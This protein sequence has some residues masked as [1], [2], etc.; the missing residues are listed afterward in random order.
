M[1]HL[2]RVWESAVA[3]VSLSSLFPLSLSSSPPS[4]PSVIVMPGVSPSPGVPALVP[5][6]SHSFSDFVMRDSAVSPSGL[7]DWNTDLVKSLRL[8][9]CFFL[10]VSPGKDR[11]LT[12]RS[13][14]IKQTWFGPTQ[15]KLYTMRIIRHFFNYCSFNWESVK[16][17][18]LWQQTFC[19]CH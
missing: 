2:D 10:R 8:L 18:L 6:L 1:K 7:G 14:Q 19:L 5:V 11:S 16:I 13:S 12:T 15:P 4:S 3:T 9:F 17:L